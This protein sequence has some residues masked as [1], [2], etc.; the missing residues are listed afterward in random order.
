MSYRFE[1][2]IR[3]SEIGE[4]GCLTL[5]ALL[6]YFQDC[7]TFQSEDIG[8]GMD[9]LKKRNR[10]WVLAAWQIVVSRYP[11]LGEEI[12]T[13]TA[14]YD[15]HGVMGMRNYY[16]ETK[17]GECLAWA[18]TFWTNFDTRVQMPARIT[19][20]DTRGYDL[21]EKLEMDYA[22]RKIRLPDQWTQKESFVVQKHHLDTNHHVNNVQYIRM[23][24]DY[25]P[26]GFIIHQ[27]RAEYKAQAR[28][29]DEIRPAVNLQEDQVTVLLGNREESPYAIVEFK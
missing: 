14:P 15:F 13:V 23:A 24:E 3:Y 11:R 29:H 1:S 22:P 12:V 19:S 8:Q 20:E 6:D 9:A 28:L 27:M 25:L 17:A 18:N 16:M 10:A 21:E 5:P 2:R 26:D 7:G 4:N